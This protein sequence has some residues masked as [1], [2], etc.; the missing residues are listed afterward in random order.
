MK[1]KLTIQEK[2]KDLRVSRRL[3]LE[4][5]AAETGISKTAL[6]SYETDEL[7]DIPHTFIAALAEYYGVSTDYLLGLTENMKHHRT[8]IKK[9]KIDDSMTD[10]LTSGRINNR[11]LCELAAHPDFP[12]LLTDLEIYVDGL[13]NIQMQ[14]LNAALDTVRQRL[15][16]LF[17]PDK[18]DYYM[19]LLDASHI[20]DDGYFLN[21]IQNDLKAIITDMRKSHKKDAENAA[22][23]NITDKINEVIG[24][25]N[26]Y[27]G[28]LLDLL[29]YYFC[30]EIKL[31]L[32]ALSN[33]EIQTM[34]ALF[35]R[36]GRYKAELRRFHKG[37]KK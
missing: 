29:T 16:D 32:S 31:P 1:T 37:R 13:I 14:T 4:Q 34:H 23:T 35:Q 11:L 9:L 12:K 15:S 18:D 27:N 26:S 28:N 25:V 3:T 22:D 19:K 5:L 36:S 10:L 21:I 2:L 17:H 8:E 7:K 6:S 33:E 20:D 30:R 24:D